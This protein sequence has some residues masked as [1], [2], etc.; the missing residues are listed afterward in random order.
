MRHFVIW[1]EHLQ[2]GDIL[3][4]GCYAPV[5]GV[6]GN[7]VRIFGIKNI[8]IIHEDVSARAAGRV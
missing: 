4:A 3:V 5:T 1:L 6:C 7:Y 8:L 2:P